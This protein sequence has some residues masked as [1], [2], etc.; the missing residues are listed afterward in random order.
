MPNSGLVVLNPSRH[1]QD[2]ILEGLQ[3]E[4]TT[5]YLFPDQALL[6]DVF[7]G[8]WV[9]LPYVYNGLRFFRSQG[10]HDAI[11]RDDRVKNIHY[12][13]TPKPWEIQGRS[14]DELERIW[15]D[16][17]DE[18]QREEAKAGIP[19]PRSPAPHLVG[20]GT[21]RKRHASQSLQLPTT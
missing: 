1:A 2:F 21:Q 16:M 15:Q 19:P 9:A 6:G 10:V 7:E 4:K 13:L 5:T 18:R 17:N 8:R 20:T 14:D 3:E 12:G 11:W